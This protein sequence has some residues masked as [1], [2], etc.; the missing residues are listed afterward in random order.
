MEGEIS[1]M[2]G[3]KGDHGV[4]GFPHGSG[5]MARRVGM[6]GIHGIVHKDSYCFPDDSRQHTFDAL[7]WFPLLGEPKRVRELATSLRSSPYGKT[8]VAAFS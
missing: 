2:I 5:K 3:V 4:Q 1:T 7:L 6:M 8:D